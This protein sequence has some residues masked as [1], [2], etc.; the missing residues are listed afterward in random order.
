MY[1]H[2][3]ALAIMVMQTMALARPT[4]EALSDVRNS[5]RKAT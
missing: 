3:H 5:V 1:F 4:P 2:Q